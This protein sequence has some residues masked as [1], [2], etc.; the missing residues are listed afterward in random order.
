MTTRDK[1][2]REQLIRARTSLLIDQPFFGTLALRLAL[3]EDNNIKT[4]AVDG[5]SIFYNAEFIKSMDHKL[6]QSAVAHEVM[7]CVF[8]H[9]NRRGP[10]Q[11]EKWNQAGD[12]IINAVLKNAGFTIG[13]N[14]LYNKI[15]DG[16]TTD[17]VYNALPDP[18]PGTGPG[19]P[20]GSMC[21]VQQGPKGKQTAAQQAAQ[22]RNWK[23][24][25]VQAAQAAKQ[26]GNLPADM[27]RFVTELTKPQINWKER[28]RN[29]ITDQNMDDYDW[30]KPHKRML[31]YNIVMPSLY[32]ESMGDIAVFVDT[33]GSIGND[34]LN[35]FNSELSSIISD[36]LPANTHVIYCDAEVNSYEVFTREDHFK[37]VA[38]GGGG[39]DFR[40]PF[41]EL[42]KRKIVPKCA[43][44]L[45]D[46]YGPFPE[47]EPDY[48]TMWVMISDVIAP[49]GDTIPI[50]LDGY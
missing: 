22:A 4:L 35:A 3:V 44:Y 11:P 1:A 21:S 42:K 10:R 25:T 16:R 14:W 19:S 17:E 38:K 39:T 8:E 41:N 49:F 27:E 46:G 24:M 31:A 13:P 36:A 30:S 45:T 28:L 47:V 34:I 20:G 5:D 23:Q 43:V 29:F 26:A 15:Y 33:S 32:S 6:T 2:A 48:P 12:Y 40:P 50:K 18:P 37:L 9:I 7:H